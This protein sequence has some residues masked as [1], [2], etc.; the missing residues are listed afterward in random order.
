MSDLH[1]FTKISSVEANRNIWYEEPQFGPDNVYNHI[2]ESHAL[3]DYERPL[4]GPVIKLENQK[5]RRCYRGDLIGVYSDS[6][7]EVFAIAR[8]EP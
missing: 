3:V 7:S 4:T 6:D 1:K 2:K 5:N 8:L